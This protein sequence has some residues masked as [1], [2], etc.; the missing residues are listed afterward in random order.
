LV[1]VVVVVTINQSFYPWNVVPKGLS[2]GS[3]LHLHV[4]AVWILTLKV[5]EYAFHLRRDRHAPFSNSNTFCSGLDLYL[6]QYTL[7]VLADKEITFPF[8]CRHH[9][10]DVVDVGVMAAV[11]QSF[12]R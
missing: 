2:G 4:L 8:S 6:E 7:T 10:V 5:S 3:H 9:L 12:L 1:I 11:E